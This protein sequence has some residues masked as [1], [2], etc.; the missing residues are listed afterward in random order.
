MP[1]SQSSYEPT[2]LAYQA[3]PPAKPTSVMVIGIIG[4][5]LGSMNVICTPISLIPF[6]VPTPAGTNPGVDV[7]KSNSL[8]FA[9]I[10][11]ASILGTLLGAWLLANSI[12]SVMLKRWARKG[13]IT[14]AWG[15]IALSLV[16]TAITLVAVVPQLM[17]QAN[18]GTPEQK[19]AAIG[20]V[21]GGVVGGLI[22]VILPIFI[23]VW[24]RKPH[25]VEAF[26]GV[27]P[28]M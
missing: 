14:Y 2:P 20:G 16:G 24:Y 19:G 10:I 1:P 26:E 5:V 28:T 12:G 22:G 21:I 25:V 3:V 27:S 4:I 17:A 8:L 6:I 9:W 15:A 23:L 13:M 7:M 11:I 18:G